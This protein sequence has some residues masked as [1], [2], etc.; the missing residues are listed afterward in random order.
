MKKLIFLLA[1]TGL[2]TLT[3]C[4][5]K[6]DA[7]KEGV[8]EIP[9]GSETISFSGTDREEIGFTAG[10]DWVVS[11]DAVTRATPD[12]LE[13]IPMSG[14][15]GKAAVTVTTKEP[16][17]TGTSRQAIISIKAG[18]GTPAKITVTQESEAR[19]QKMIT[20]IKTDYA[21]EEDKDEFLSNPVTFSYDPNGDRKLI[22]MGNYTLTY[23]A[24]GLKVSAD[25]QAQKNVRRIVDLAYTVADNKTTGLSGSVTERYPG[26]EHTDK[27][28]SSYIY[29][30]NKISKVVSTEPEASEMI[31]TWANGSLTKID[32]P[33]AEE[34]P[35]NFIYGDQL[36]NMN[37][38]L[39]PLILASLIDDLNF[40]DLIDIRGERTKH[41]P[42]KISMDGISLD[43][44]YTRDNEGY[45]TNIDIG[46][47]DIVFMINYE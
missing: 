46:N 38:N 42:S 43:I 7:P 27:I 18:N 25:Y 5:S 36:N 31:F 22:K 41:L 17:N 24:P 4:N 33:A 2:V 11:I 47:S 39:F 32:M 40:D 20:S 15:A 29:Q 12:W 1:I 30:D 37:L 35:L 16:N 10:S 21:D 34:F 14:K 26:F 9:S 19:L 28:K 45:I 23:S 13:V 3:G 8:V 6:E 44:A